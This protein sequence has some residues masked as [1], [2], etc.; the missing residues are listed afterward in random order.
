MDATTEKIL[1]M[2]IMDYIEHANKEVLSRM[3]HLIKSRELEDDVEIGNHE[4]EA[5]DE[6]IQ[7]L[8]EGKGIP[9]EEVIKK[10]SQWFVK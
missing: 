6:G 1:R 10:Y 9:H 8:K 4:M 5:I 3:H 7:Q 2:E